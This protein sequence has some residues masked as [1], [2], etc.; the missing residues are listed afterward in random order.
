LINSDPH[1]ETT[2]L[3]SGCHA[4]SL[5]SAWSIAENPSTSEKLTVKEIG[6]NLIK[7]D[8]DYQRQIIWI[9][10]TFSGPMWAA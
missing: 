5:N 3:L 9:W 2:D 8:P 7:F 10:L 1:S 6:A 4:K